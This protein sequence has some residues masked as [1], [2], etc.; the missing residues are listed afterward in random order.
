MFF[1]GR[2]APFRFE[3]NGI[4]HKADAGQEDLDG[5]CVSL[6]SGLPGGAV[7]CGYRA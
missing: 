1:T 5:R 7:T 4:R 6:P 2:L 3:F